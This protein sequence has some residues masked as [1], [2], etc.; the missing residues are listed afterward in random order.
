MEGHLLE[1]EGALVRHLQALERDVRT[2]MRALN[3]LE[4]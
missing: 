2:C 1:V 4:H 3:T